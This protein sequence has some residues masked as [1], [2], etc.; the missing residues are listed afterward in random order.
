[1][2]NAAAP[3]LFIVTGSSRGLGRALVELLLAPQH[4]VLG[5]AR[6]DDDDALA[7]HA[8]ERG[9]HLEQWAQ[10]LSRTVEAAQRLEHWLAALPPTRFSSAVLI[11]NAAVLPK[12]GP[13][14]ELPF[15]TLSAA[16]RLGLEAPLLLS[17]AFLRGTRGWRAERRLL[18]ISSS[19]GRR[20]I[21][22][23]A[24][25]GAVKA[26]L[27]QFS[28]AFALDEALK[29]HG[30]RSVALAPGPIDTGMQRRMRDADVDRVPEQPRFAALLA[31]GALD[32]P[33]DAAAKV[34]DYLQRPDFGVQPVADIADA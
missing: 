18:H 15:P 14:D 8:R 32:S 1:M 29:D 21:A 10:D 31:E 22:G 34:I 26:G 23:G 30:A 16:L 19:L 9:G 25:Y 27:D 33:H 6:G 12:P 20:A 3:S 28:R 17:T 2:N 7:Q 5:I 24:V 11:N 13:I 4:H